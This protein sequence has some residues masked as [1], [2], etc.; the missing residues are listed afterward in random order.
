MP[1]HFASIGYRSNSFEY[2]FVK[3]MYTNNSAL[4]N[5][6]YSGT[7]PPIATQG[8]RRWLLLG[9]SSVNGDIPNPGNYSK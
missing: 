3:I 1:N 2:S 7:K 4:R 6:T 9:V 5:E 8:Q